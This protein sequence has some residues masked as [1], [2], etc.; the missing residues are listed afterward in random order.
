[1]CVICVNPIITLAPDHWTH[2][3]WWLITD[4][5]QLMEPQLTSRPHNLPRIISSP[6][7]LYKHPSVTNAPALTA[8]YL[9]GHKQI[10]SK[11]KTT[12]SNWDHFNKQTSFSL[13]L[14][15]QFSFRKYWHFTHICPMAPC[16]IGHHILLA[17]NKK[18]YEKRE[19]SRCGFSHGGTEAYNTSCDQWM[20]NWSK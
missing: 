11:Q 16:A 7:I 12:I 19:R 3:R 13:M 6:A 8:S 18:F 1:M 4:N 10:I 9:S 17:R 15:C 2:H 14:V 20:T 5:C